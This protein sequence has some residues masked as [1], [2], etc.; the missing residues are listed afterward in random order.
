MNYKIVSDSSSNLLTFDQAPYATVPLHILV[1]DRSFVDD[2]TLN[3][4]EMYDLL[5]T[6]KGKTST[7]CPCPEDWISAFDNADV[8]FCITITSGLSGACSSANAAKHMYEEQFPDRKVYIIDSLSTGPEMVLLIEK[9]QSLL[10]AGT[11]AASAYEQISAYQQH[12]RLF[13]SLASLN[14]LA[15]NGRVNPL[16]AKGIG[17][18]GIRVIGT[19]SEEGT[20]KPVDKARGDKK[21]M[22]KM[23]EH[24]KACGYKGGRVI[25]SH[26][27]NLSS[28]EALRDQI[29]EEFG[30]FDGF[31]HDNTA[32][33]G[34]YAEYHSVMVGFETI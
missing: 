29:K 26:S 7:S 17:A 31:I 3:I 8:A 6:Y 23:L 12:T 32:L 30:Y 22:P 9:L 34:Y 4:K 16:L 14:N 25:I 18:L 10:A 28:A 20:L 21:A 1:G 5:A 27:E 15:R 24:M 33:C 19:A 13:F 2:N 11:D